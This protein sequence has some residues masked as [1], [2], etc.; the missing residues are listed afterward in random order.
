MRWIL[1]CGSVLALLIGAACS[2]RSVPVAEPETAAVEPEG[3][4]HSPSYSPFVLQMSTELPFQLI[5]FKDVG[6]SIDPAHRA[7]VY[8]EV[9]QSLSMAL[10][11]DEELPMSSEVLYSEEV[12]DPEHHLAC[13]V[14]QIYVDLWTPQDDERWGYSL[15]SGCSEDQRFAWR[16]VERSSPDDVDA[17]ARDIA[18]TLRS[19]VARGC[20]TRRC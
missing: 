2:S 18:V 15:W 14:E 13:G 11:H 4:S 17:L 9:A 1:A 20:F 6:M 5:S 8:E 19:A 16:E 10:A 3:P 7:L 12:A